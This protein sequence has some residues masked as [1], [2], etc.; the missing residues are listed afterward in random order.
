L[1]PW[2][3]SNLQ[4][5]APETGA[6][7]IVLQGLWGD[8]RELNP[9]IV[10]SQSTVL[11]LHHDRHVTGCCPLRRRRDSNPQPRVMR[12][13]ASNEL[14]YRSATPPDMLCEWRIGESNPWPPACKAGALPPELIPLERLSGEELNLRPPLYQSGALDRLSYRTLSAVWRSVGESNSCRLAENQVCCLYTNGPRAPL[15][16]LVRTRT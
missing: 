7:S 3:D 8:R 5:P 11:P 4:P 16:C 10:E 14:Q 12:R 15:C 9:S 13:L 6:L 1:C 2:Q